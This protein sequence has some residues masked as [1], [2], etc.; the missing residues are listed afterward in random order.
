MKNILLVDTGFWIALI[1]QS[2]QH[3]KRAVEFLTDCPVPLITTWLVLA[4]TYHLLFKRVGVATQLQ[5]IDSLR[6]SGVALY[7]LSPSDLS[8]L[9]EL[10]NKY[11]DLPMDLAD[12]S[13]VILAEVQ[14]QGRILSTDQRDFQTYRWKNHQPFENLLLPD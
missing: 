9:H 7:S 14:G 10:M 11:A 2:D 12:G 3:H 8:R 1:N 13:L 6:R 5:F 4:E